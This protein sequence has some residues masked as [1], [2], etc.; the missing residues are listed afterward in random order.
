MADDCTTHVEKHPSGPAKS[1]PAGSPP[2][3]ATPTAAECPAVDLITLVGLVL[4]SAAGLRRALTP[5][6]EGEIG[7][8]GQAFEILVR[9]AR[10]AGGRIR[11]SDLAAQTNLTP[12]GLT[13]AIDR[14]VDADLVTRQACPNDRRGAF[15]LLTPLGLCRTSDALARHER[16]VSS[17][18]DGV[19][20]AGEVRS[21]EALLRKVR[22][23]V[24][25]EAAL[26][27][28]PEVG[29]SALEL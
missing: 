4:E 5:G 9:L 2:V 17:V 21:L 25:P 27:S 22:D 15:A 6:L 16:E 18:L 1:R 24:H 20:T 11:M 12:G 23:R 3:G 10:S 7:L 29:E 13:R 14:L 8:R 26:V 28:A 19:L